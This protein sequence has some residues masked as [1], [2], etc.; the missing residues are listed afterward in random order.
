MEKQTRTTVQQRVIEQL[1]R[2]QEERKKT[3]E[4]QTRTTVQQRA[5]EQIASNGNIAIAYGDRIAKALERIAAALEHGAPAAQAEQAAEADTEPGF[6]T[7]PEL[8]AITERMR[9]DR[10]ADEIAMKNKKIAAL[11]KQLQELS[12]T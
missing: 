3:M 2:I 12:G 1:D 10:Y 8:T 5:I 11:E 9:A 6:F 4:K 7:Q